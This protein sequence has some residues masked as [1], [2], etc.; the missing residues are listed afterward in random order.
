MLWSNDVFIGL[1]M[2]KLFRKYI[3]L[4]AFNNSFENNLFLGLNIIYINQYL[5]ETN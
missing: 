3:A 1:K 5:F 2:V 4:N